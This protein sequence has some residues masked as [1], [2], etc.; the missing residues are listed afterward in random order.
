MALGIMN[1]LNP[2]AYRMEDREKLMHSTSLFNEM[3]FT[4]VT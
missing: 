2:R 3:V 4:S 1:M